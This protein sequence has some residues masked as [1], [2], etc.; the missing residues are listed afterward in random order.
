[1]G[2]NL[3]H[4]KLCAK[5]NPS[6]GAQGV[7]SL[8]RNGV[9]SLLRNALVS[10]AENSTHCRPFCIFYFFHRT[11]LNTILANSTNG[12]FG[13]ARHTSQPFTKPKKPFP[14]PS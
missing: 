9:V 1:L 13:F 7:V 8:D 3:P 10:F 14:L 6:T 2:S 11:S 4:K 12:T 5:T